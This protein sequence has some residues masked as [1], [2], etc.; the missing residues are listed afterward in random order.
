MQFS[1]SRNII[2]AKYAN[3]RRLVVAPKKTKQNTHLKNHYATI[4]DVNKAIDAALEDSGLIVIQSPT[5]EAGQAAN[6]LLMETIIM[7]VETGEFMSDVCQIPLSKTDSQGFGST[8]TYA[9]RYAKVAIFDLNMND[10]D[11][12]KSVVTAQDY[13]KRIV[14]SNDPQEIDSIVRDGAE[15]FK[16]DAGSVTVLRD[17]ALKRKTDIKLAGAK[18]FNA[19]APANAKQGKATV[20]VAAEQQQDSAPSDAQADNSDF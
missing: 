15:R 18:T 3:C 1:E 20:T 16:D 6:V 7:H 8:L 19:S 10:D 17:A 13:K 9:R 14:A 12:Q 4:D 11:G 2:L 5:H